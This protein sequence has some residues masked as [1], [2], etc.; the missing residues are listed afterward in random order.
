M[1]ALPMWLEPTLP[2]PRQ[3]PCTPIITQPPG[4]PQM[5]HGQSGTHLA[6][7]NTSYGAGEHSGGVQVLVP[8]WPGFKSQHLLPSCVTLG[9][10]F[11]LSA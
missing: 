1:G 7:L 3:T 4:F 6:G 10:L 8:G 11:N 9:K 2:S 5:G